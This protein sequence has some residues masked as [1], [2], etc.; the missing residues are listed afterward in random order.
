MKRH[1]LSLPLLLASA[2]AAA[3]A[4]PPQEPQPPLTLEALAARVEELERAL[5]AREAASSSTT[6]QNDELKQRVAVLERQLELQDEAAATARAS[7]P[8]FTVN[9]KGVA[10]KSADGAYEFKLRGTVQADQ[11]SFLEGEGGQND[12]F[13]WRIVRPTLEG[14]LGKLVAFKLTPDFAGDTPSLVDA[15][16]DLRFDPRATL[17]VGK[18]NGPIGLE[19]LQSSSSL[20]MMERA[21]PTELAPNRDIGVQLQGEFAQGRVSYAAGVFNGA[22]DGRDA[23]ASDPDDEV[24]FEGRV[25]F[26]PWK[27]SANALSGL[28][29]GLAGSTGDKRGAGNNF[30]PRYR[31]PGQNVFFNYR[32]SVL[33][34]GSHERLSPQFYYY[35]NRLGLMGEWIRSGQELQVGANAS[36]HTTLENQA[37][38]LTAGWVLTGEDNAYR[39]VSKPSHPF[40]L[41]GEGWGALELVARYGE[42]KVDEDAFPVYADP[43]V[44]A[45]RSQAWGLGINWYLNS[46]LKLVLNYTDASFDGGAPLGADRPDEEAVFSRLQVSF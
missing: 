46:N 34:D 22:A 7:T 5:A 20:A 30:L 26:E 25:F 28:G 3:Q 42:L 27:N 40:A 37:W 24:E 18:F 2:A 31:T 19:R 9:D 35:R 11:R 12:S 41:D 15:Y 21:F 39:G 36:T 4:S 8:V 23:S 1:L 29:F 43:S 14:Q 17:R 32:A 33:A 13:L 10:A 16:V 44:S 6:T 38:Q 45:R